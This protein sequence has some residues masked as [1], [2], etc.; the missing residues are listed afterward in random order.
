MRERVHLLTTCTY[1]S[2]IDYFNLHAKRK[3][4][5]VSPRR[6]DSAGAIM[7][8]KGGIGDVSFEIGACFVPM[9]G[10]LKGLSD[11]EKQAFAC[12][13]A[14]RKDIVSAERTFE[15]TRL[16]IGGAIAWEL[17]ENVR[18][19]SL[20][21]V[22]LGKV[23]VGVK[24]LGV[25]VLD[26]TAAEE[27]EE[28]GYLPSKTFDQRKLALSVPSGAIQYI[29]AIMASIAD[30]ASKAGFEDLTNNAPML[31]SAY[32]AWDLDEWDAHLKSKAKGSK[33][34]VAN[35]MGTWVASNLDFL[36]AALGKSGLKGNER[37]ALTS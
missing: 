10:G 37:S 26:H 9:D 7:A 36:T 2:H 17:L 30:S 28:R 21:A 22:G 25:P 23:H 19:W 12:L 32:Q 5:I 16:A 15:I 13:N 29:A 31:A 14:Y 8:G 4:G 33:F 11:A 3:S 18:T 24:V 6:Y 27:A 1:R 35:P 20:R 34:T